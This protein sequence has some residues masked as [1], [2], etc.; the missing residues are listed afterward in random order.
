MLSGGVLQIALAVENAF[1]SV[2]AEEEKV[3]MQIDDHRF[4]YKQGTHKII[5]NK[6]EQWIVF[7]LYEEIGRGALREANQ[8]GEG[9]VTQ[10]IPIEMMDAEILRRLC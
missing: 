7:R 10:S 2:P 6:R 9:R 4:L 1:R 5:P 3:V 8:K